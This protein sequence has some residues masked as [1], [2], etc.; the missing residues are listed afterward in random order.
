MRKHILQAIR[1]HAAAEYPRE[2][3]GLIVQIGRRQQYIPC[4]NVSTEPGDRFELAPDDYAAAEDQGQI[5]GVVHSHPDATSRAS[6]ADIALCNA[7]TVP[8]YILSWPE[9]DLN[10]ITPQEDVPLI[11]RPF[12][13]GT[14]YDCYGL[15][16]AYYRQEH[17]IELP[18][19]PRRD[20]WWEQGE[21]LYLDL[22]QD[23]GFE[24]VEDG[25]LQRG[26]VLLMQVQSETVNHGAIYLGDGQILHHLYGRLSGA[27]VYG[28]YWLERTVAVVRHKKARARRAEG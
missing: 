7:G 25:S 4:R 27:D 24:R 21:N 10:V 8:W 9:G 26:D 6:A 2:C 5:V 18:D 23:A 3:C 14:D 12:V 22:F 13:H 17:G 15:I 16:R 20:N 1:D 28:G 19:Y 11:G